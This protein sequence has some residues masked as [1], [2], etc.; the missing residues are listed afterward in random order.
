MI[1]PHYPRYW[2]YFVNVARARAFS[3]SV[4]HCIYANISRTVARISL[5]PAF[6]LMFVQ[7]NGLDKWSNLL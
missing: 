3:I 6:I 7:S 1:A 4:H 2:G 5:F